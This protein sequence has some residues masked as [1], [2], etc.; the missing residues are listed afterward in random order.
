MLSR[1]CGGLEAC[2]VGRSM[3][4]KEAGTRA[5][6]AKYPLLGEGRILAHRDPNEAS[7]PALGAGG[8]DGCFLFA[9]EENE[10]QRLSDVPKITVLLTSFSD[11]GDHALDLETTLPLCSPVAQVID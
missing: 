4:A 10:A 11:S 7:E 2:L 9:G 1:G 6:M 8:H 5:E 3:D